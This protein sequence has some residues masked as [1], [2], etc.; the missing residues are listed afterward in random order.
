M[1]YAAQGFQTNNAETALVIVSSANGRARIFE[2]GY[3]NVGA[4]TVD[5]NFEVQAKRFTAAGASTAVVP[6]PV[7][8]ADPAASLF[9]AGANCTVEPTYTAA[10]PL[11]DKGVN[12]RGIYRFTAYTPTAELVL[13]AVA[14]NG[15]GFFVAVLGGATKV[16][17]DAKVLQ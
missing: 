10:T 7:D 2:F 13:P 5:S 8:G 4:I 12:P 15:I 11:D 1:I 6:S 14:A 9:S 16:I 3:S 17:V